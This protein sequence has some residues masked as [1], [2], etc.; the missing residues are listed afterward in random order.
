MVIVYFF[1]K[2]RL[3]T[4]FVKKSKKNFMELKDQNQQNS[5]EEDYEI[6]MKDI[7]KEDLPID[8]NPQWTNPSDYIIKFSLYQE[9]PNSITSTDTSV[10][11]GY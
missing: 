6:I 9:I 8:Q 4:T 7:K 3:L 11:L 5:F 10:N 2:F 1:R